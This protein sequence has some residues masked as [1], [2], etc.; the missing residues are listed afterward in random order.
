LDGGVTTQRRGAI[1]DNRSKGWKTL[2]Y[3]QEAMSQTSVWMFW[4][5][6]MTCSAA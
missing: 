2:F 3:K 6:A 1:L 5:F 4:H